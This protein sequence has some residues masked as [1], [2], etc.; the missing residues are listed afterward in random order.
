MLALKSE[1]NSALMI[2]TGG[3]A[4]HHFRQILTHFPQTK[5]PVVCEPA[6]AAYLATVELFEEMGHPAPKN[7]PNLD[8]L[9]SEY[10]DELDVAFI[11]SPHKFHHEQAVACLEAGIDVLLEKPMVGDRR[12]D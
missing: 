3:M 9:L 10:G 8:K 11:N 12:S 2:G 1:K 5:F 6:E 7:E 4:R